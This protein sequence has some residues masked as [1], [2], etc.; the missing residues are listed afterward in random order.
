[1]VSAHP[2]TPSSPKRTH[3]HTHALRIL[4]TLHLFVTSSYHALGLLSVSRSVTGQHMFLLVA[5]W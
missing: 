1:M 2:P 5:A 4:L 3:T